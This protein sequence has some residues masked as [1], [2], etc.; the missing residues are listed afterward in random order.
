M[1]R[2]LLRTLAVMMAA[3]E[4]A[5]PLPALAAEMLNASGVPPRK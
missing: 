1:L 2:R 3:T 4:L 5:A